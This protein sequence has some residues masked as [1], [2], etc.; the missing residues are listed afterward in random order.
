M[1]GELLSILQGQA[2][3]GWP[4]K[5]RHAYQPGKIPPGLQGW[6]EEGGRAEMRETQAS[7]IQPHHAKPC[8]TEV[9][10]KSHD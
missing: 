6:E 8:V 4:E 5:L 10:F 9:V 3:E 7:R 2:G 1:R